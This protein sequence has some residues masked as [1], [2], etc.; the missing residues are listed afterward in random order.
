MFAV[1]ALVAF[2]IGLIVRLSGAGSGHLGDPTVWLFLGL[3][4]LAVH[5]LYPYTP[6]RRV[7]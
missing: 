4:F 7:P 2:L 1:L 3:A 5:L 6:W